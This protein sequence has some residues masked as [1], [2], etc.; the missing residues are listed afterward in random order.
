MVN[1]TPESSA[2]ESSAPESS[3]PGSPTRHPSAREPS[4]GAEP[5][6][7]P[8]AGALDPRPRPVSRGANAVQ[9]IKDLIVGSRLRPGDPMPTENELVDALGVSRSSVREALRTLQSLDIVDIQHGRGMT[10]GS[11]S[12]RPMVEAVTFRAG[13]DA[14]DDLSVLREVV[15]IRLQ[16]DLGSAERLAELYEGTSQSQLR[17]H[18]EAMR[19]AFEAGESFAAHDE[20]FHRELTTVTGNSTLVGLVL[21]FW[22]VHTRTLPVLGLPQAEDIR[23]TIEAHEQMLDAL[24]HGDTQAYRA[25]VLA[26]YRPL[27]RLLA[28]A[29]GRRTAT[30]SA[31]FPEPRDLRS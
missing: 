27:Q 29:A 1:T 31:R 13:L 28:D 26:H 15:D 14:D 6:A 8:R 20:A 25:A 7:T 18:V 10:V 11:L 2:P 3:A 4:A 17:Q 21:G 22:E 19:R 16:L 30:P 24:E 9:A 12:L 23:E 5:R